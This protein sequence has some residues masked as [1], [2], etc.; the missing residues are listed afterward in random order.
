MMQEIRSFFLDS[1]WTR[2]NGNGSFSL[3]LDEQ[4]EV[5]N[6]NVMYLDD[7]SIIGSIP[8]VNLN[9]NR[10]FVVERSPKQ[11]NFQGVIQ[12]SQT[13]GGTTS[14][15]VVEAFASAISGLSQYKYQVD[16]P[17]TLHNKEG[18]LLFVPDDTECVWAGVIYHL[19]DGTSWDPSSLP[20]D[21]EEVSAKFLYTTGVATWSTRVG[22]YRYFDYDLSFGGDGKKETLRILDF[23]IGEYEAQTY[24]R[25]PSQPP[26]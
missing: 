24:P 21:Y 18:K 15:L 9:N 26:E 4:I 11:F 10:V 6:G 17:K 19:T 16:L 22:A 2:R 25:Y 12:A 8:M 5:P 3:I 23:P 20:N 7:V 1:Q 14:T 13:L